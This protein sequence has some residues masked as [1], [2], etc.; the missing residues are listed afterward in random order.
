MQTIYIIKIY[1]IK[2]KVANVHKNNKFS[3]AILIVYILIRSISYYI[4]NKFTKKSIH[5]Q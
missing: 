1:I 2:I 5:K 3:L 4:K